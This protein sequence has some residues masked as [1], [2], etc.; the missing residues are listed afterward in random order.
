MYIHLDKDATTSEYGDNGNVIMKYNVRKI[1]EDGD[2]NQRRDCLI[3][4]LKKHSLNNY[5]DGVKV[6]IVR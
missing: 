4:H 3:E 2:E 6:S 5:Y 1:T